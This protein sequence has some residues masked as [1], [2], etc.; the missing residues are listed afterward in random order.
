MTLAGSM[1]IAR[2]SPSAPSTAMPTSLNGISRIQIS[3][4][5]I[6]ASSASGQHST[7]RMHQR[8]NF[9]LLVDTDCRSRRFQ[10]D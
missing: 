10:D 9:T 3:G 7:N 1:T 5:T 2:T 8:R 4:Y 6:S